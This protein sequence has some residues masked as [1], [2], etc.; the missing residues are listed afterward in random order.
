MDGDSIAALF[1]EHSRP[2][3]I[4]GRAECVTTSKLCELG[5]SFLQD[6][7]RALVRAAGGR[8]VLHTYGS[9]CTPKL[10]GVTY[11]TKLGERSV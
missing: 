8:A 6:K 1:L 2:H 10:T 5:K 4:I 11:S 7:A 3:R 9:D